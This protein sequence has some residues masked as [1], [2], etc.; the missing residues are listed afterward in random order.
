[1]QY[2]FIVAL[3]IS[4]ASTFVAASPVPVPVPEARLRLPRADIEAREAAPGIQ[5]VPEVVAREREI[6]DV[7]EREPEPV[8]RLDCI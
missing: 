7:E 6:V 3:A 8:C 4:F 2:K 1:M 5:V